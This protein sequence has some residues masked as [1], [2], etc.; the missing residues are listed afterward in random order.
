MG[1]TETNIFGVI[2]A[3]GG[4]TRFWPL[5]RRKT[6]KQLL[7]LSGKD[8]LINE[9]AARL[10]TVTKKDR[11]FVVAG[12]DQ[13]EN[14]EKV[15]K[16]KLCKK[17]ILKEPASRNTAA[18]IGFA[19]VTVLKKYGD[20]IM[21]VTPSDAYIADTAS[22]SRVLKQAIAAADEKDKLVT[23]GISPTHPSTG[24]GYIRYQA[25][26]APWKKVLRFV[27]KPD[28][29]H[30]KRYLASGCYVWNSGMFVFRASTV[31]EKFRIF[32][33][34]TFQGL[35]EIYDAIGTEREE[36][37]ISKVYPRLENISV[38]YAIMEKCKDLL[39]VEG[40]F[41]WSDVGSFDMLGALH[42]ADGDGNVIVG[43]GLALQTENSVLYSKKK[44]IAAVGVKDLV[45]V[46]TED[47]VLVCPKS[48]A[49]DVKLIVEE[50]KRRGRD[51]LL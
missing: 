12:E 49:Q 50:L 17:N 6:P 27:E 42:E 7:D 41:G 20:G 15:V 8:A 33:P 13:I 9:A 23:V 28:L 36:E 37:I 32:L 40:N 46:S 22:F 25:S 4:G 43:D 34:E 35:M 16:G 24:Y 18:C 14:L 21:V 1:R 26:D 11:I 30:A 31:L 2:M 51:E 38:D 5:S 39:M 10:E 45:I 44:L 47:A 3:G 48:R 29:A 19:A